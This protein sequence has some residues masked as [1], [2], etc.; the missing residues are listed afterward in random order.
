M[1]DS[2]KLA[3]LNIVKKYDSSVVV[4][5]VSVEVK[6]S[7]FF[8]L[9]GSSGSGKTTFLR[10][11][12]GFVKPDSGR[13]FIDG[14]DITD[15]APNK[16]NTAMVFQNFS[17]W[18]HMT[19]FENVA[20]GLKIKKLPPEIIKQKVNKALSMVHLEQHASKKP[21]QLSGGQQ[22]RVALARAIVVEP[23]ILLLDEP[24]S[25]LDA[26]LRDQL[27]KEIK[28]LHRDL[29]I[30]TVYV[31]HDQKEAMYLADRM[32]IMLDGKI[33]ESGPPEKLYQKPSCIESARFLGELNEINGTIKEAENNQYLVETETGIFQVQKTIDCSPG[34]K[35]ILT[36][37]PEFVEFVSEKKNT[38]SFECEIVSYEYEGNL[39]RMILKRNNVLIKA[40]FSPIF[41]KFQQQKTAIIEIKTE[42]IL[43]FKTP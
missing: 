32:A 42:H 9:L 27:R 4:D 12:A 41:F 31:T 13:I 40:T 16:R 35:V 3:A 7:E 14:K 18:P 43:I 39:A 21:Q 26:H 24:L 19:V 20:F 23:E 1:K 25:N 28:T 36:F 37:R 29:G 8:A 17:L 34:E 6:K 38:N 11:I 2:I 33:I 22:Q 5:N 15:T 30:T 10:I